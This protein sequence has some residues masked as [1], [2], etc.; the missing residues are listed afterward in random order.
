MKR[1]VYW[2]GA[3]KFK[4]K[5][6]L[7]TALIGNG[8]RQYY[9]GMIKKIVIFFLKLCIGIGFFIGLQQL[10]EL[11][12]LG[13]CLQKIQADDLP[14]L[15]Q[16]ATSPL[17]N[18]EERT[19]RALLSQPYHLIGVGSECFAF[20]S[21][22]GQNVIKF[23]KLGHARPVYFRKGLF[24]EDYSGFSGTISNHPLTHLIL[25]APFHHL[26]Q[27]FLG[28]REFRIQRTFNSVMLAYEELKQETGLLYLHLNP[29]DNFHHSI[30]LYDGNG[31]RHEIDL[32]S[33]RFFLQKRAIPLE[34]HF[35]I[36]SKNHRHEDAKKSIDSL[37]N[38]I[39]SRCKKSFF[40]RDV[41]NKNFGFIGNQ[42]IEIDIGSFQKDS[43][44]QQP[45]IYKQE[46]FY[47]TLELK[48]WLKKHYPEMVAYLDECVRERLLDA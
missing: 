15:P 29:S 10:I 30:V 40:D 20:M 13:F 39:A 44:M 26:L 36:L 11:K 22:D 28:M 45:W 47:S 27:R 12:T 8:K 46:L 9:Y 3:H 14:A 19:I 1:F 25:P 35:A 2:K 48:C 5:F 33:T 4:N 34:H 7:W 43:R 24:V 16:W 18:E 37:L 23:F 32:D 21:E 17:S 38:L 6:I 31:I 41:F 42:A